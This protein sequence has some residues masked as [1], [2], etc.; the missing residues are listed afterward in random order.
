M[1]RVALAN[2]AFARKYLRGASPLGR[3]IA[4]TVG[5]PP[6]TMSIE[7][8]VAMQA[9]GISI[10][11]LLRPMLWLAIPA[12]C[13]TLY[14]MIV[15]IP[16][17]NQTFR[18][19]TFRV[20]ATARDPLFARSASDLSRRHAHV[21]GGDFTTFDAHRDWSF[22]SQA[23][24]SLLSGGDADVQDDGTVLG[25]GSSGVALSGIAVAC[26]GASGSVPAI[27]VS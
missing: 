20:V 6:V 10:F 17:Q 26:L 16:D 4:S 8:V 15:L 3:T 23:V 24:G 7:V 9:C 21:G 13:A 27:A 18:E 22:T 1:P 2:H 14:V 25:S 11:R 19:I 5:Q 12:T